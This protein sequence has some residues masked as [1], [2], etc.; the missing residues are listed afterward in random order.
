MIEKSPAN[1]S[2]VKKVTGVKFMGYDKRGNLFPEKDQTTFYDANKEVTMKGLNVGGALNWRRMTKREAASPVVT[3]TP[4][5]SYDYAK[6]MDIKTVKG[7]PR[8][9]ILAD[10]SK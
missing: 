1:L 6:A 10:M 7:K 4:E 8:Q 5:D 3:E 9:I 2:N